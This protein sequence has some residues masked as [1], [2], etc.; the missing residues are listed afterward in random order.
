MVICLDKIKKHHYVT[1]QKRR[2]LVFVEVVILKYHKNTYLG[3][4]KCCFSCKEVLHSPAIYGYI[5]QPHVR[6]K[7]EESFLLIHDVHQR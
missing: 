7:F 2:F 3:N 4:E 5:V 6:S 1:N